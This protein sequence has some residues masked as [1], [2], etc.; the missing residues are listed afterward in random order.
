MSEALPLLRSD[1]GAA[2]LRR[3]HIHDALCG[4]LVEL[5]G[6]RVLDDDSFR[7]ETTMDSLDKLEITFAIEDRF[8]I[9]ITDGEADQADTIAQM[10]A[11]V[12]RKLAQQ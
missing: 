1:D 11:L 7:S 2:A 3:Q 4:I 12:E 10:V 8:G 9:E 6:V 5:A